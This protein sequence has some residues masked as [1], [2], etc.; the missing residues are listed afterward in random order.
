MSK[1]LAAPKDGDIPPLPKVRLPFLHRLNCFIRL[2]CLKALATIY[3]AVERFLHPPP[4]SI[5]PTLLKRYPCRPALQTRIFYPPGYQTGTLLPVYLSI[6]GGGFAFGDPQ[7]DDEFCTMWAKRTGMLVVSLDYSKAPLHPFPVG[8]FDVGALA[9]AVLMDASLPIDKARIAMGGFSAGGNLA[10]CASQLPGLQGTVKAVLSFYPIVDWGHDP[11]E[12]LRRRPY[13]GGPKESLEAM[14]WWLD[15]GYVPAGQNR[16]DTLLSPCYAR[17]QDLP[18][19]IYVIGAQWDMLRLE[20][21]KMIHA[22]AGLAEK[23]SQ[24][25][26]FELG[27]YKWTLAWGCKHGFTHSLGSNLP[28]R[29]RRERKCKP[30]YDEAVKWMAKALAVDRE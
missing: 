7:Q 28:R 30:I 13:K 21:Q 14:S 24:E 16:H 26:D 8:V 2:W 27:T 25:E 18:P 15:W 6:H 20:S 4:A 17:K 3:Y 11:S 22:L 19:W 10:L 1:T 29:A 12:K 23:E 9:E 5:R